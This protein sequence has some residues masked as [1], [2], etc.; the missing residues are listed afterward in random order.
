MAPAVTAAPS[1]GGERRTPNSESDPQ[2]PLPVTVSHSSG[3]QAGT[4]LAVS[5]LEHAQV[6]AGTVSFREPAT[7]KR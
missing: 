5:L 4:V 2:A 1:R 3:R 6:G 7:K